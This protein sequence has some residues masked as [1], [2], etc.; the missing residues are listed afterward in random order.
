VETGLFA[1]QSFVAIV[2]GK[3]DHEAMAEDMT[4][5]LESVLD[6]NRERLLATARTT[7]GTESG[8]LATRLA[9]DQ[10]SD[11]QSQLKIIE[12]ARDALA[13]EHDA[14]FTE[15]LRWLAYA[16]SATPGYMETWAPEEVDILTMLDD[17]TE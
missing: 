7:A 14:R 17:T 1:E 9:M 11:I 2:T 5:W 13:K 16:H 8:R 4:A 3:C 6:R 12:I 10:V 15:I